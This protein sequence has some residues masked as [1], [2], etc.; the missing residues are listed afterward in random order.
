MSVAALEASAIAT[1]SFVPSG[2]K[3]G[4]NMALLAGVGFV[5]GM[6]QRYVGAFTGSV[7]VRGGCPFIEKI[8]SSS[9]GLP[10]FVLP[11]M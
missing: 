1:A 2:E 6:V 3:V 9:R 4:E 11:P 7:D 10:P 8:R 5:A